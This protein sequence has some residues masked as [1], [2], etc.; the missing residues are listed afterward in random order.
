MEA[1]TKSDARGFESE[2]HTASPRV[3]IAIILG[4]AVAI[5][6]ENRILPKP[7]MASDVALVLYGLGI[8]A[9]LLDVWNPLVGRWFTLATLVVAVQLGNAWLRIPGFLTLLAVPTALAAPFISLPA[10]FGIA[11]AETG[12]LWL[13]PQHTGVHVSGAENLVALVAIWTLVAVMV[14]T[15]RPIRQLA[16]WSWEHFQHAQ[17]SLEEARSGRA[18]IKQAMEDL[19]H[20]NRQLALINEKLAA[21][22]LVAEEA[23]KAKAAFVARVSHEFRTPLNMII[24]LVDL[25]VEAPEVYGEELPSGLF[26]DLEIVQ[27]NCEHL[28]SMINDV[29]DLSQIDAGRLALHRE[30]V[31]LSQVTKQAIDVVRPLLDKKR[32]RLAIDIPVDLPEVYCDKT[33]IRQVILNLLSNAAR[34]T[35]EGQVALVISQQGH[36]VT[37]SVSDTGPGI[38]P[39]DAQHVFEPFY[40]STR[41]PHKGGGSGLGLSISKQFVELHD[42]HMWLESKSGTGST[43]CFQL[44]VSPPASPTVGPNRWLMEGWTWVERTQR[45][46]LPIGDTKHRVVVCDE[47]GELGRLFSRYADEAEY[48]ETQ[49]LQEAIGQLQNC[50]AQAVLVNAT[51]EQALLSLVEAAKDQAPDIPVIG[52]TLP[53]R[54][55]QVLAAGARGF[56]PKPLTRSAL[57]EAI[58]ALGRRIARVLVVDDDPDAVRLFKRMLQV[59][60]DGLQVLVASTGT[61]A[62]QMLRESLPDLMLLDLVL[63]DID[64]WQVLASKAQD[65]AVRDIPVILVSAQDPMERP[66]RSSMLLATIGEGLSLSKIVPAFHTLTALLQQPD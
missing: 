36:Y 33:R 7:S 43:F 2:L 13:L 39:E 54:T 29:L 46:D 25:L 20:A 64:G 62:L 4:L 35:E 21:A 27:R 48:V 50:P 28:A 11:V 1:M 40:Q 34:F 17:E 5:T 45:A 31:D 22:R 49:N 65:E 3:V 24:G 12:M 47:T 66:L 44:P 37:V 30:W 59:C 41:A 8:V 53:L 51:S 56:V 55:E 14:L 42:G 32:I 15:Y 60:D 16:A 63:P 9:L 23:Q 6:M 38:A 19:S 18:R 58:Q 26:E 10:A 57:E 61:E 52:C